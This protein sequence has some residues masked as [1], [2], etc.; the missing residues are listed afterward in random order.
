[1]TLNKAFDMA[2]VPDRVKALFNNKILENRLKNYADADITDF[3]RKF[4]VMQRWKKSIDNSDLLKTKETSVQGQFLSQIFGDVLG[5][6][7]MI[8]NDEWNIVHELT[9]KHDGSEADGALGF[10]GAKAK[11]VRAVIELKDANSDLDK[12]QNRSNHLSP[13][14]QGFSYAYKNGSS[15]GWVIVSNFREIR[16]YKSSSSLEY[17]RFFI[18]EMDDREIF[19]RFY[20]LLRKAHLIRKDGKSVIDELYVETEQADREISEQFYK[21]YTALRDGLFAALKANNADYDVLLLFSKAQKILDRFIFICFCEDKGLLPRDIFKKVLETASHSFIVSPNR[22]WA[23]LNGLFHSID[24]G[25]PPMAINKYNG[26]LFKADEVLDK[27]N[28]P[29]DALTAFGKLADCDF[30]SDLN[31]NILGHIFEHSIADIERVKAEISGVAFDGSQSTRKAGGIFYTPDYVTDYIVRKTIGRWTEDRKAEIRRV[32]VK[33]GFKAKPEKGRAVTIKKWTEIPEDGAKGEYSREAVIRL[34][35]SF[36]EQYSDALKNLRVL[37]PACG[38]GA[39]LNAAFRYILNEVN[40]VNETLLSLRGEQM[41]L[42]DVDKMI[43]ENNLCGV[44]INAESVEI[45]KLSLWLQTANNGRTLAT[46]EHAVKCGNSLVSDGNVAGKLAFDW[47]SEFAAIM[48]NGG[49]DVVIG[50]PPYGAALSQADKDYLTANYETTE[51]NFDT[52]KTFMELGLKLTKTGGYMGFITPN[53]WFVLENGA[54]KLRRFLFDNYTLLNVVEM[55]NVFQAAVVEPVISVFRKA[56]PLSEYLEVVSVPRKTVLT[57]TFMNDG[58]ISRFPQHAL[59]ERE[60]YL[61]NFR[62][63]ETE[64]L[65]RIKI[66]EASKPLSEYFSVSA[67]V[68]PFEKGKGN[69]PQTAQM[70]KERVYEGYG[71]ID[72]T[73]LP[74]IRGKSINRYV[75]A[76][77]GEYIKYGEWLAAP[78]KAEMFVNPKIFIRQTGDYP[79]ATY[80][81]SGKIGKNTIHCIYPLEENSG[82][83]LKYVLALIN[84]SLLKWVF[85]HDNFHIVGKPLAETKKIYVERLPIAIAEDMSIIEGYAE[86]LMSVCQS[87]HDKAAAFTRFIDGAYQPK[88]LTE[89]LRGFYELDFKAFAA[90]LNAQKVKL[91]AS[92]Q[93]E[94]MPLFDE[95]KAE[96]IA[97]YA[98]T[99]KLEKELDAE[100]YRLY[101][102]NEADIAIIEGK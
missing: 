101:G 91:T 43:L 102:L 96:V 18:T 62:E 12:K 47:Q 81:E 9:S 87:A 28:I 85:Q 77:D 75:D 97:L 17:E 20:Y 73:W 68:K 26:G 8:G 80:D 64:K 48:S 46:L 65:L 61:F 88:A 29:D 31:V 23:Q 35:V 86:R 10:F 7:E 84:S 83:S 59:R 19:K 74:Y 95:K 15:C 30:E 50:N 6:A 55:F 93:M 2:A 99:A 98:Q 60:G 22:V 45:T 69:P 71:K 32:L 53:T 25:N 52:Y 58:V 76:W 79:V 24:A 33:D 39:F 94:L 90:E 21:D 70:I 14:E 4:S 89:R 36:W 57:S 41:G 3:E 82:I 67:G 100:V 42:L 27:L 78:R 34:H 66:G 38:S 44:D 72:D 54:N 16:L 37:D 92:R 1:M 40:Y 13:I 49:F 56:P 51:Y 63:T 5:Y 11:D